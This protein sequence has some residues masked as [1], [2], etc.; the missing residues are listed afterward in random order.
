MSHQQL[1]EQIASHIAAKKGLYPDSFADL[2]TYNEGDDPRFVSVAVQTKY[3][4]QHG[5]AMTNTQVKKLR[6][7]LGLS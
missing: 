5:K 7:Q 6:Q 4:M 3:I 1:S 2:V